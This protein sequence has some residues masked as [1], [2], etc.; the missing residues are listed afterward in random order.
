MLESMERLIREKDMIPPGTTVLCALSGGADSVCL[1]HSLYLLR[2]KLGFRLAAAHFN[3]NLRGEESRRDEIFVR[4]FIDLCCGPQR[5]PDGTRLPAVPL[6]VGSGDVLLEA[7]RRG[8]GLEETARDMRYAFLRQTAAELGTARIAT[9]HT[10]DDNAETVL[11]HLARGS[12]LRGLTGI[13]PVRDDLIRPLLTTTRREVETY[14]YQNVLPHME[15]S[16]NRDLTF[17]RNRIRHQ[18]VPVLEDLYPGFA[19]RMADCAA[20]LRAD[21]ELLESQAEELARAARPHGEGIAIPAEVLISA[22]TPLSSRAVR[23]LA[24]ALT[25]DRNWGSAHL[26][27]VLALCRS[28]DPSARLDLPHGLTARR[29]YDLLVLEP[30]APPERPPE[31]TP[32]PLPGRAEFGPWQVVCT[33]QTYAV[34]PQGP[35]E[36]WLDREKLPDITLRV[37]R[38]GDRLM[39]SGRPRKTIK[40][41]W[42]EEKIPA[43]LRPTLPLLV[44]EAQIA[45]AAGLGPEADLCPNPGAPAWHIRVEE[46][47]KTVK[48]M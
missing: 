34:Q 43:H 24:A 31:D 39:L 26:E 28:G 36:F 7:E 12:G 48:P 47:K 1:L 32:L 19:G 15:D 6:F 27:A 30:A 41:W 45:A 25:D 8:T 33:A 3:H 9:A 10:A 22:P 13:P 40:K 2:S 17:S 37:R 5:L 35:W 4:Q 16:S 21:D 42:V 14:L 23:Q 18:V 46:I 11:L 20:L 29:E 44:R 38:T